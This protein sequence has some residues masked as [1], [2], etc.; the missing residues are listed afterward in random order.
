M[1]KRTPNKQKS[2]SLNLLTVKSKQLLRADNE[3]SVAIKSQPINDLIHFGD[4]LSDRL[5]THHI[6]WLSMYYPLAS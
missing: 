5:A 4:T 1:P 3:Q 2:I 6:S